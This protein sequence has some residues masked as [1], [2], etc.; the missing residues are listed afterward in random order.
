MHTPGHTKGTVSL[1]YDETD[2]ER[3]VRAGMFGGAGLNTLVPE[4]YDFEGCCQAYFDSIRR[5]KGERVE[6]FIGNH[7]WN[8]DTYGKSLKLLE[9]G[10]NEF[11][12]D[13]LWTEF[14]DT[15]KARLEALIQKE[16]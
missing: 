16:G 4:K 6:L 13:T 1:F 10:V 5:L 3:T 15:Y 2:G 11:I 12:N 7:T 14:L 9:S 8:N